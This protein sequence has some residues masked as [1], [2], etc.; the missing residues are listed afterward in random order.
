ML[1]TKS[2][3]SN[4]PSL[5]FSPFPTSLTEPLHPRGFSQFTSTQAPSFP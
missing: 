5:G 1:Q 3:P 2:I 4:T